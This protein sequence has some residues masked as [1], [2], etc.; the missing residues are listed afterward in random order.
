MMHHEILS[1]EEFFSE[2]YE[3]IF[4]DCLSDIYTSVSE[5]DSSS[6]Y[7]SD[8]DDVEYQ[9]NKDKKTSVTDSDTESENET[10][11]AGECSFASKEEQ[12]EDKISKQL[13]DFISVSGVT[14]E[15]NNP[16]KKLLL[17]TQTRAF[18]Y[19]LTQ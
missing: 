12:I 11:S 14:T 8:S 2:F 10:H 7:S 4:S 13:E 5:D 6:E 15:C 17:F 19:S 18:Q 1:E 16:P 9:T 3:D